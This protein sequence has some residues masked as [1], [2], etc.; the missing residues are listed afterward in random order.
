MVNDLKD[1]IDLIPDN[2]I[3][4]TSLF[5]YAT[6]MPGL[7][8]QT[9]N[10]ATF[11]ISL[12]TLSLVLFSIYHNTKKIRSKWADQNQDKSLQLVNQAVKKAQAIIG[13]AE[14]EEIKTTAQAALTEKSLEQVLEKQLNLDVSN[15]NTAFQKQLTTFT[16][17]INQTQQQYSTFI[18]QLQSKLEASQTHGNQFLTQQVN[19][20]A[21]LV[22]GQINQLF[23]QFERN[24]T[25]FLT[26]TEQKSLAS[27]DLELRAARQLVSTYKEQQLRFIDENIIAILER[28]LGLVL[29][30]KLTL[31]DQ[32][33][34]VY[35][36]LEKAKIEEFII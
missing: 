23:E 14:L 10:I 34:L 22:R 17:G 15:T 35:E 5:Q 33:D 20:Q 1:S 27:I 21:E 26:Q 11:V 12:I 7:P 6:N 18:A 31:Q 16:A 24:I 9:I 32:V 30:K 4:L 29:T 28:T 13:Q 2:L 36:A 3:A 25:D 8:I 19:S